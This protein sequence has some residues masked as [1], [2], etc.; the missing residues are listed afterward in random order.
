MGD[1]IVSLAKYGAACTVCEGYLT[2]TG[3]IH[4]QH[5]A[6]GTTVKVGGAFQSAFVGH[7]QGTARKSIV[8]W[9]RELKFVP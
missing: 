4:D 6:A 3:R 9:R 2:K 8:D 1:G 7:P 5:E